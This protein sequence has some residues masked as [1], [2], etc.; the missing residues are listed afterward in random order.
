MIEEKYEYL[1][2]S[3]E[4]YIERLSGKTPCPG[5]GSAAVVSV[6]LSNALIQMVCNFSVESKKLGETSKQISKEILAKAIE[7]QSV[8]NK[9]IEKDSILYEKIQ[10]TMKDAKKFPDKFK[11]YQDALKKSVEFHMDIL[12][13]CKNLVEWN[14]KLVEHCNPYLISDVGVSASLVVGAL[15][16]TRV[17]IFVNLYSINDHDYISDIEKKLETN[18]QTLLE[19]TIEVVSKVERKLVKR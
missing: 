16:A 4:T 14:E 10:K 7:I 1:K 3:L 8:L 9:S 13:Y 6:S 11:E 15:K 5:G 12:E 17:N 18:Y 19:K 2:E